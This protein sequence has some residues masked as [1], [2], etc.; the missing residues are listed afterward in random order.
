MRPALGGG[1]FRRHD[2]EEKLRFEKSG[3][4]FWLGM[5][6]PYST[7][8]LAYRRTDS[9]LPTALAFP[10]TFLVSLSGVNLSNFHHF[11]GN[12]FIVKLMR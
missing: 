1:F 7:D 9:L 10:L 4:Y 3:H 11:Q 6:H 5:V 8:G 2:D 12:I